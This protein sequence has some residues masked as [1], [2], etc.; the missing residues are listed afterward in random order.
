MKR[1][2]KPP[3]PKFK[4]LARLPDAT[5]SAMTR[6]CE[7]LIAETEAELTG[8]KKQRRAKLERTAEGAALGLAAVRYEIDRRSQIENLTHAT[9]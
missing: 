7:R 6:A 8:C 5:L 4:M 1:K 2:A 9:E 3:T